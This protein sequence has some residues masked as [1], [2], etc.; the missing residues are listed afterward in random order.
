MIHINIRD[1]CGQVSSITTQTGITLMEAMRNGGCD[2]LLALCG[3]CCSCATC[4][5]F[6]NQAYLQKLTPIARDECD[7]LESS[8]H[9]RENS[10]LACQ[11][12]LEEQ[13][14][15]MTVE[16]APAD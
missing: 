12:M 13:L 5:V 14:D 7:L 8:E 9:W 4:H 10:R 11:I 6:I 16:I 15:G 1:L 3:G 2:Q